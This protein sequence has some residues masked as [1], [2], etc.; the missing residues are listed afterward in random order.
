MSKLEI[1]IPPV[2]VT[3]VF[4]L[5]MWLVSI[6]LPGITIP[7]SLR[8]G[9]LIAL[10]TVGALFSISGVVSFRKAK[11][12]VNPLTPDA[13]SSLVSSGIYKKTRNPMYV[14]FLFFLIG[15]GLFLSNL[16]SLALCA[17]FFLYMNRFQIQPEEEILKSL[18]GEDFLTYKS[19]VR[20][21][22]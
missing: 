13:C 19:Q 18:F 11:T 7:V 2:L 17:S 20:R 3:A 1:K 4:A 8:V 21:W 14:G 6:L 12:S 10:I 5:L 9:G 15:W 22:L 16:F